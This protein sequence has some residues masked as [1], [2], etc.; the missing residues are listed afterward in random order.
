[1]AS[2]F[3]EVKVEGL[4]ELHRDLTTMADHIKPSALQLILKKIAAPFAAKLLPLTPLG[5][6][7]NLR[8][9]VQAWSPRITANRPHAM[10][11]AGIRYKVAPHAGLVEYGTKDRY[12]KAGA[13]RGR[14]PARNFISPLAEREL[15]GMLK[16]A[17]DAIWERI[18]KDWNGPS[19]TSGGQ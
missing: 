1:M 10:A 9:G 8:R 2:G 6:T 16:Q 18:Y 13:Y 14:G 5:P 11:R 15:P 12:T 19:M 7:G 17:I 4:E 3:V